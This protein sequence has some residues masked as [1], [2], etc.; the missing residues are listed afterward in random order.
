MSD[1]IFTTPLVSGRS[2]VGLC[3]G[4]EMTPGSMG[5]ERSKSYL[6]TRLSRI[7]GN[8]AGGTSLDQIFATAG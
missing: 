3:W 1:A 8:A 2:Y 4:D 6:W 7:W 5:G